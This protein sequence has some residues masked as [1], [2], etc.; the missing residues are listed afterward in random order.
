M[1]LIELELQEFYS[2]GDEARFFAGLNAIKAVKDLRGRGTALLVTL[3]RRKLSRDDLRELIALVR[4]YRISRKPLKPLAKRFKLFS[5][6]G[7]KSVLD[8]RED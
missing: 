2:S 8:D 7:W 6:P 3:D 4:R 5:D 1:P